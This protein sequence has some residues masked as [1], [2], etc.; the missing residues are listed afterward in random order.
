M[1]KGEWFSSGVR[2]RGTSNKVLQPLEGP[3]RP[4]HKL[5]LGS[6]AIKIGVPY[7]RYSSAPRVL[8]NDGWFALNETQQS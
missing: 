7:P 2:P 1:E 3:E 4:I 6:T 5:R 8:C